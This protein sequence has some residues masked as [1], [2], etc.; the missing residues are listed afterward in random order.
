MALHILDELKWRDS[1]HD[2]TDWDTLYQHLSAPAT[3]YAGFDPTADSLH[4][5][6]LLP[7]MLLRRFQ[8][9]GHRPILLVGGATGMIGDPSFKAA[10]R[11]LLDTETL[12]RNV[13]AIREQVTKFVAFDGP[14]AAVVV[15]N[16][17]WMQ[18][19][20]FLDFLRDVGKSVTI[21][22]MLAKDSVKGRL[23]RDG[24]GL[25]YTEFSYMLLQ[26]YDFVHLAKH[27]NCTVQIGGSDQWGN[28]TMG[29]DLGR[30]MQTP[31]LHAL[32]CPLLTTSAGVK[33][34]KT[35]DGAVWL[36]AD[37]TSPYLFYQYFLNVADEDVIRVL[38]LLSDLPR[39]EVEELANIPADE[40]YRR[41]A[42]RR[43]A[44]SLTTLVHGADA[45]RAAE[46]ASEILFGGEIGDLTAGDLRSIFGDVPKFDVPEAVVRSGELS[47]VDAIVTAQLAKSKSEARR[48][49]EGG[50][51]YINNRRVDSIERV[52]GAGDLVADVAIVLRSGK[53][54]YAILQPSAVTGKPA[55]NAD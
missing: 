37:K 3:V 50:S 30:R 52:L 36:D 29:T 7:L 10:E 26:G 53:K 27:H 24:V 41:Q 32:T 43:L 12:R 33:M 23:D 22:T 19:F 45:L 35:V 2:H 47:I 8:A 17:D 20:S 51:I 48:A 9:A 55:D 39:E 38:K 16:Y 4:V 31:P 13:D 5:G 54:R 25:S 11:P 40:R 14:A 44:Q 28:I 42:Q 1:I 46:A 18:K 6:S 21:A 15:N 49:I 34:G